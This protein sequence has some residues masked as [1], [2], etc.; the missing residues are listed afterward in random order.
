MVRRHTLSLLMGLSLPVMSSA[1]YA[2][3]WGAQGDDSFAAA[4]GAP[5]QSGVGRALLGDI[6]PAGSSEYELSGYDAGVVPPGSAVVSD[7]NFDPGTNEYVDPAYCPPGVAGGMGPTGSSWAWWEGASDPGATQ[8][9]SRGNRRPFRS[10]D[11]WFFRTEYLNWNYSPPGNTVLGAPIQGV[12]DPTVPREIFDNS[13]VP[14]TPLGFAAIPSL[15]SMNLKSNNGVRGTIGIPLTFGSFEASA[16]GFAKGHDLFFDNHLLGTQ[17]N[18]FL[19]TSTFV[20]GQLGD[21][22]QLYNSFFRADFSTKLY[23]TEMN[24]FFDATESN[25]FALKPIAGFKY[26]NLSESLSQRGQFVPAQIPGLPTLLPVNT[27]IDSWSTNNLFTPQIGLRTQFENKWLTVQ[28]DPKFG[29]AAD[30]YANN[31]STNHFRSNADPLVFTRDMK[32]GLSPV[33]DLGLTSR[34][35]VTKCFTLTAGYNLL[36]LGRVTR[37]QNN[38]Y[39]NDNGPLPTPPGVVVRTQYTDM[40][41][42]GFSVGG[43]IRLP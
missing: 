37:P 9:F 30:Y 4:T 20:N 14:P 13:T 29:L 38:I 23:A 11:G 43:E 1:V 7:S 32:T 31:V 6:S 25:F 2:D 16:L 40:L 15:A 5:T 10:F 21:N 8:W 39:Y 26:I 18:P 42:Y 27:G 24:V 3:P 28:F 41:L 36:W 22:T 34:F 35:R 19:G 12:P 17:L 33:I